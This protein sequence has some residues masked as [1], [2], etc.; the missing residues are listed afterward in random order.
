MRESALDKYSRQLLWELQHSGRQTVQE[1]SDKIGLSTAPCW[2]R[3]KELEDS[4]VIR[5]YV[6][7]VDRRKVGLSACLLTHVSLDRHSDTVVEDFERAVK[8]TP[9]ILE[10]YVTTGD[11]DYLLK[12]IVEDTEA[13]DRFLHRFM[14]KVKGIRQMKTSVALREVK[15]ETRLRIP[16]AI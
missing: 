6:A 3:I 12:I 15:I 16:D 7:L 14:F 9:E 1:L 2:R 8:E 4:G 13:Y 11:A 5:G 10:C